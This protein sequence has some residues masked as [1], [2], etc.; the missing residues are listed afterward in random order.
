M[1]SPEKRHLFRNAL[2]P[3]EGYYFDCGI[4]T[5]FSLDLVTLLVVPLSLALLDV[6][7]SEQVIRDPLILL[8]GLRRYANRLAIFC[9]AGRIAIPPEDNYLYRYMEK[10]IVQVSSLTGV[11]H[12]KVWLLRYVADGEA[13]FYRMLCLSR[14]LTF[15]RSW[16]LSLQL[17]GNLVPRQLG[18]GRNRPLGDFIQ[19][20]P[21]LAVQPVSSEA[22]K[23]VST[24]QDEARRVEF[25]L[26]D[27]FYQEKLNFRP[28]GIPEYR[29]IPSN[30]NGARL[31]VVSPFLTDSCLEKLTKS[32][33]GHI[34]VSRQESMD[35]LKPETRNRFASLY[36][37]DEGAT[38]QP[39][40]EA[41]N[42]STRENQE[43]EPSGLHAKLFVLE[44]GS[45]AT[46]LVGSANATSAAFRGHNVEF[47][48][49]MEG[50]RSRV[51]IDRILSTDKSEV[52]LR[53]ILQEY[54]PPD[55]SLVGDREQKALEE[56]ADQVRT[57][58]IRLRLQLQVAESSPESYDMAIR[59]PSTAA[60][61]PQEDYC[62]S[63][64][65]VSLSSERAIP[66]PGTPC[67]PLVTFPQL[68]L[69]A[70]T[71]FIAFAI[72]VSRGKRTHTLR[73][74]LS[75]PISGLPEVRDSHVI[76]A[77]IRNQAE[78][79]RYLRL[80]LL[81]EG[82]NSFADPA[83]WA[84]IIAGRSTAST[85][86]VEMDVPLLETLVR[87]MSRAPDKIERVAQLVQQLQ[88]T[89]NG[90]AALSEGFVQI[91]RV[92]MQAREASNE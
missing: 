50:D 61:A 71:P 44:H 49:E 39:E 68:T 75:L 59:M 14:N 80:L 52:T 83:E 4:G 24:L 54:E 69:L 70:L 45:T 67:D 74:V 58:L 79:L 3:P 41:D 62:V 37:L 18:F 55:Q 72:T 42:P 27:G 26:P 60:T 87:A 66:F 84:A 64:W 25:S 35:A 8:E 51:G 22:Q 12:P 57:W 36:M 56:L 43:D 40:E 78:F 86:T 77:I 16:D 73:F 48:V 82:R 90:R 23:I 85:T 81:Q 30:N 91:W 76:S 15:D 88:E 31:L 32:G 10:M 28:A 21:G 13:P 29:G 65:P 92:L 19:A 47:M 5:T 33:K 6:A 38:D 1:I 89:E 11:F 17:E 63:C 20:L 46:W 9:Q 7:D 2:R 34:L 53:S